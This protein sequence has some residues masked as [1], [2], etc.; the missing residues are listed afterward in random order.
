ME[1]H[2]EFTIGLT[3]AGTLICKLNNLDPVPIP[4]VT[5]NWEFVPG[6][7][8]QRFRYENDLKDTALA[9]GHAARIN[10]ATLSSQGE[11]LLGL[12][13]YAGH[14]PTP[15]RLVGVVKYQTEEGRANAFMF[16]SDVDAVK[17]KVKSLCK[18]AT[19]P[20]CFFI[21]EDEK[22][23]SA[24]STHKGFETNMQPRVSA[25]QL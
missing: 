13:E 8:A 21:D 10:F 22:P 25:K 23:S 16:A 3:D 1:A 12:R 4:A 6:K 9:D 20:R 11:K 5:P 7:L 17:G 24:H 2:N 18:R 19:K 15:G 14:G